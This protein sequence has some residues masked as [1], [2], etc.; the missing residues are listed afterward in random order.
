MITV[1]TKYTVDL[2]KIVTSATADV[3]HGKLDE[4][5]T[6]TYFQPIEIYTKVGTNKVNSDNG[7]TTA[8]YI[9][10]VGEALRQG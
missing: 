6:I 10:S 4:S 1:K 9:L 5:G 2:G 7:N 3:I 8:K